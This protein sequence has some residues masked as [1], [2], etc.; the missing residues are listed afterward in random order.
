MSEPTPEA[1]EQPDTE[2]PYP[3]GFHEPESE[4]STEQ[5]EGHIESTAPRDA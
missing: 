5:R 1:V 3:D 4:W 2:P